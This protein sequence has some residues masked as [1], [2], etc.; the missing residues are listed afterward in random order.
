[1]N[2]KEHKLA[3]AIA[4]ATEDHYFNSASV[5]R[6]LADQPYYTIDRV[7]ELVLWIIEKSARQHDNE[8]ENGKT[9]EGL[10]LAKELDN[11]ANKLIKKYNWQ[12]LSLP[13]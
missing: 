5:A 8:W 1:M 2:T 3:T 4:N 6:Y 11:V 9:S 12:H 10:F 7:M 13:K